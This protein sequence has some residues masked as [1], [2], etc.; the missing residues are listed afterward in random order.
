MS[1]D[2]RKKLLEIKGFMQQHRDILLPFFG[3]LFWECADMGEQINPQQLIDQGMHLHLGSEQDAVLAE[4]I[5]HFVNI[6]SSAG[7]M[8]GAARFIAES[9][10]MSASQLLEAR[11]IYLAKQN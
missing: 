1:D 7:D 10:E 5:G 3:I 4:F 8:T 9:L 2:N 11:L 6:W